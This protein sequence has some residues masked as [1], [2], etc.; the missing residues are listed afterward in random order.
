LISWKHKKNFNVW[1][2]LGFSLY[3]RAISLDRNS[4]FKALS[5]NKQ[6]FAGGVLTLGE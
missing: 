1:N 6:N 4:T 2:G 5:E 3:S